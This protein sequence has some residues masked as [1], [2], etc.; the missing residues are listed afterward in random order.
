[1]ARDSVPARFERPSYVTF[2]RELPDEAS[3]VA[4]RYLA[5]HA[6]A[7]WTTYYGDGLQSTV[8]YLHVALAVLKTELARGRALVEAIRQSDLLL[9]HLVDREALAERLLSV[10]AR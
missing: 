5:A 4:G 7:A 8:L 2:R 3:R 10:A 1:M 9:R 6:F